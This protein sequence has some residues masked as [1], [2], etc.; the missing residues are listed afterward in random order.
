VEDEKRGLDHLLG[1]KNHPD[2]AEDGKR[3]LGHLLDDKNHPD[4]A[5]DDKRGLAN[6]VGDP[7]CWVEGELDNVIVFGDERT[8]I[9]PGCV[10][11]VEVGPGRILVLGPLDAMGWYDISTS[12][13]QAC[14]ICRKKDPESIRGKTLHTR[15]K[16]LSHI[17]VYH[18]LVII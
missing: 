1:G 4:G 18:R 6:V 11:Q 9:V 14:C 12:I 8:P 15:E 13:I 16:L 2:G 10:E 5:E 17:H 7:S 3:G